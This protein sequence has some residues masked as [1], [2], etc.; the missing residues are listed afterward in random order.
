MSALPNVAAPTPI[1][2]APS[3]IAAEGHAVP[4]A[5][6]ASVDIHVVLSSPSRIEREKAATELVDLV[7]IEGPQA[8]IRLGLA[9]AILKGLNDKKNPI[10]REGACELLSILVEQGVGNAVEPFFFEKL[11]HLIVSETFADKVAPVRAAALAA[12]LSIIQVATSWAVPI[13]LPI[14]LEQIK[15]AGKWQ[16]K[17][18]ALTV[19][20]QLVVSAPDQCARCMPDIIPVMVDAIWGESHLFPS[21]RTGTD[22]S[23]LLQTPSPMSRRPPVLRS[24][25]FARSS[26]TRISRSS[27]PR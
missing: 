14:L 13:F 10:A 17:T 5:S 7:K 8:F 23:S 2:I 9:D 27:S 3:A 4:S 15:T 16:V 24:P 26:P 1:K 18:G 19:M 11:M 6:D 20:D 21:P 12:V 22:G 25:S